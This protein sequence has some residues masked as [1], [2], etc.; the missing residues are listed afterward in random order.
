[1]P[2]STTTTTLLRVSRNLL[3]LRI[4]LIEH[5]AHLL[6]ILLL[7]DELMHSP[8]LD[9]VVPQRECEIVN[10]D[11]L[12]T[13]VRRGR[14]RLMTSLDYEA[15]PID[16]VSVEYGGGNSPTTRDKLTYSVTISSMTFI[17]SSRGSRTSP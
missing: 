12:P 4:I 13:T 1:M 7:R 6:H 3:I 17:V 2:R 16:I 5:L 9:R 15:T 11:L 14:C 10:L 8:Q